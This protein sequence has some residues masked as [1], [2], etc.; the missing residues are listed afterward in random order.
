MTQTDFLQPVSETL[1]AGEDLRF[2]PEWA[3][4]QQ[5]RRAG[6]AAGIAA[7][8]NA[9]LP[10]WGEV[11]SNISFL[12][13]EKTKDLRLA[14]WLIEAQI[15]V[16]GVEGLCE[17][18]EILNGL[19]ER[20]WDRGL[21]PNEDQEERA[22]LLEWLGR[23]LERAIPQAA[24]EDAND[25]TTAIKRLRDLEA[26]LSERQVSVSFAQLFQLLE[27]RQP[28]VDPEPVTWEDV[29]FSPPRAPEPGVA[30]GQMGGW[31][32]CIDILRDGQFWDA[33]ERMSKLAEAEPS[34]RDVFLRKLE[35]ASACVAKERL[36][37]ARGIL[38]GLVEEAERLQLE[39]WES[40]LLL[41]R[42]W[43]LLHQSCKNDDAELRRRAYNNLCRIAPW[44]VVDREP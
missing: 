8:S 10:D 38:L 22:E 24:V 5:L 35:I 31:K 2:S 20:F 13:R 1:P 43:S 14:L 39:R 7:A 12:L 42:M 41:G 11:A 28:P 21:Y 27:K 36:A 25:V 29:D 4:I 30:P 17:G 32:Q 34:P 40:P 23:K 15:S 3:H 9:E 19:V 26:L 44:A 16:S 6:S 18:L 33:D 37:P